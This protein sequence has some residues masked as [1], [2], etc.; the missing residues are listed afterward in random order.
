MTS[1]KG[2]ILI[3]NGDSKKQIKKTDRLYKL[4]VESKEWKR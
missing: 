4:I 1:N 2:T 3:K